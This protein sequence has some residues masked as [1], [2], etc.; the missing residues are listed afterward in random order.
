M[1]HV[2][3]AHLICSIVWGLAASFNGSGNLYSYELKF[4]LAEILVAE[5]IDH[6]T[7]G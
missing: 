3:M 4:L 6:Q 2:R 5:I 7:A 1:R